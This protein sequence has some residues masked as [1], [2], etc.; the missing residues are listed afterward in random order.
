MMSGLRDRTRLEMG[1]LYGASIAWGVTTGVWI[2]LEADT[3][4]PGLLLIA[5]ALL[6]A[7]APTAMFFLDRPKMPEG[8]PSAIATG[9]LLG[10]G[11]A[12]LIWAREY[13]TTPPGGGWGALPYFRAHVIS[14]TIGGVGGFLAHYGARFRPQTSMFV[15]SGAVWG[16]LAGGAFGGGG[17]SGSW[18]ATTNDSVFLGSLLGYNLGMLGA[19][20]AS[21]AW[22]PSYNQLMWMWGGFGAGAAVSALVYPFY[23]IGDSD[24]RTGLIFQGI[25]SLLGM[26]GGA[27]IGAPEAKSENAQPPPQTTAIDNHPKF[28]RVLGPSIL[29][30]QGG[31][32]V[33]LMGELY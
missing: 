8:R 24:P 20:G 32:G 23:A 18:R 5:P 12:A 22:T 2:D 1:Y 21:F 31:V 14:S 27:L 17:S 4:N 11:E 29:P 13:T 25:L 33:S 3:S 30:V 16:A 10:S 6:G 19:A 7:A 28:A 26:A 9:V 15:G